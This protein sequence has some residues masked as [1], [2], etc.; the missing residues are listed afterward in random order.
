MLP[1]NQPGPLPTETDRLYPL[2]GDDAGA[3]Q[4]H[5]VDWIN[6]L[7]KRRKL[8]VLGV[9]VVVLLTGIVS[10]LTAPTFTATAQFLPSKDPDLSSRLGE[11]I[12]APGANLEAVENNY[13]SEYYMELL[14]SPAFLER[15]AAR[16]FPSGEFGRE[17]DL[18]TYY[19][20]KGTNDAERRVNVC[21]AISGALNI[22]VARQTKIVTLSYSAG[23]PALAADVLNGVLDE[24]VA[25][26]QIVKGARG[27]QKLDFVEKQVTENQVLL[28]EAEAT[29]AD[30]SARNRKI[31]TPDIE[32][33]LDR[34]KR[35][36]RVQE[37]VYISLKR[38]RELT[39]IEEQEQRPVLDIIQPA[40]S[41]FYK[42]APKTKKDVIVAAFVSTVLFCGL[43]FA[44]ELLGKLNQ[45]DQR[46][47]R[48]R[49][50]LQHL[51]DM[52]NDLRRPFRRRRK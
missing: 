12:G 39:K 27:R 25:Y 4:L 16:K 20:I 52:Q 41:P 29:L 15:M 24:I 23:E 3:D 11:L 31:V 32:L 28:K 30:F 48:N 42:S 22:S 1:E 5:P 35:A 38:Q 37:E 18:Y 36:V 6:I 14:A 7:L 51:Q 9:F 34:L 13:T 49:E 33:E 40:T 17:V 10:K 45:L 8:I 43:A 2:S 47:P 21:K 19:G 44:L 26:S 46:E 50:L